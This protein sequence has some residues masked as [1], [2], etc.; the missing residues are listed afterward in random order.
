MKIDGACHCGAITIEGEADPEKVGICHCTDCQ[1]GT[2]SAFRVSVA[3]P[4][5]TFKMKG[6]P[7]T[8]VKTT[9][10]SGLPRLQAFCS[11]CGSPIYST[12]VGEGMQAAYMVR[13]GILRQRDQLTP[14][15]Q[16]WFRS[17]R[18][19]VTSLDALP[20]SEKQTPR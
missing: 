9:A 2:G 15:R 18:P 12:T 17:A 8:Y 3:V 11:K 5:S 10:D 1:T 16:Q 14:R 7:A 4:G 20:K 6:Q 13:V 19:W